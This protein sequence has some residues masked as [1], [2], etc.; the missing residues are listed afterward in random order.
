MA[1]FAGVLACS[2]ASARLLAAG[3][4]T[5]HPHSHAARSVATLWWIL[6]IGSAIVVGVVTLLVLVAVLRRR[7]RVE[8]P[9]RS[10]GGKTIVLV[11]GALVPVVV[12]VA[13]FVYVLSTLDAT[14]QPTHGTRLT[15]DVRGK[16]WFW[17]VRYP[18]ERI[19]TANELHIPAGRPVS[20]ILESDSVVHSFWTPRLGGKRDV[21]PGRQN[22]IW[23]THTDPVLAG[24]PVTYRGECAEYCGE[25]HAFMRHE[26]VTHEAG[27]FDAWLASMAQPVDPGT[28]PQVLAGK[29]KFVTTGC[30]GCHAITGND[31]AKGILG[32]DLTR[33]GSR[34]KLGASTELNTREM[35]VQ[36]IMDPNSIKPGTTMEDNHSRGP[37]GAN[38]GMNVPGDDPSVPGT[39]VSKEDAE[40]IATY[41]HALK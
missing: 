39:Q 19:V 22:R 24:A 37:A 29:E 13:L 17:D 8:E 23:F 30:A 2:C 32:P 25:S 16:Q 18:R 28:D 34:Q 20:L 4:S 31:Q 41:L 12:L 5:L 26:V 27:E 36:W 35:L 10:E 6:L 9:D 3:Q 33:F 7:G 14:A 15:I 1:I 11:S 40:A 21:I 38:D